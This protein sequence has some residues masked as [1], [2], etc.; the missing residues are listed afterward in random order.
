MSATREPADQQERD[1]IRNDL[2]VTM[3][4]EAAAG[5]GKTTNLVARMVNLVGRDVCSSASLAAIT[6]TV[7]AAAQL[8]ERFQEG[9]E[10][11]IRQAGSE[12]ER[13]RLREALDG[14]DRGFIGT[15]HA[16]CARLL[17][18]RPVEAGLDPEFEEVDE[19]EAKRRTEEFWN[20]W[21]EA[22]ALAGN[23][24]IEEARQ[25]ELDRSILRSGFVRI[26]EYPDITMV[27]S[28]TPRPDLRAAC[29]VLSEILDEVVPHLPTDPDR[30]PDAF[31][32]LI[33]AV[34]R[35]RDA[36]DLGEV[37]GQLQLLEE[38]NHA[39]RK[40]VQKRWPDAATAKQLGLRYSGFVTGTIRPLLQ[41][42]SEHVHG[43]AI[44]LLSRA[45]RAFEEERRHEG[46]LTYQDLL[47]CARDLLRGHPGVRRYFQRRFTHVLVDEF[48]DT[49]PLQAEI[50]FYLTGENVTERNWRALVPRPGSLFIVGDP[51]QSIYRF[52]RA[53]ITTYLDVRKRIEATGGTIVQLSTNFRSTPSICAFVNETFRPLFT[54][55]DVDAGRQAPHV[56]LTPV[57]PTPA[58]HGVF[59]LETPRATNDGMAHAEARCVAEWIRRAVDGGMRIRDE[60]EERA[61]R[62]SDVLL[63]S[64]QRPR[65]STYA[66]ALEDL[67]VP[68]E[69][70]GSKAFQESSALRSAMPLLRAIVDPDDVVSLAGFLRGPL[71]GVDDDAL[72]RFVRAGGAF[73]PFR[74]VPAETDARIARG[75]ETVRDAIREAE[76]HPPAAALGRLFDRI[77]LNALAASGERGGTTSGN[78][79]LALSIAR[80]ESA[81]GQSLAMIVDELEALLEHP[82]DLG[83]L[84]VDPARADAVRLMNLHQ[85]KGLEAPVVFLIDPAEPY[86]FPIDL[87]VDRSGDESRGYLAVTRRGMYG[88]VEIGLPTSWAAMQQSER[89]FK[90]AE[91]RRLL[92]VAAT[93][94]KD[95]LV[96]GF[97]RTVKG[98]EGAWRELAAR[99]N[100]RLFTLDEPATMAATRP[101]ATLTFPEAMDAIAG[102]FET[103]RQGSYSVLPITKIAHP[104]HAAL[105][106][107]EEGLGK[108]TSWGRV[109]H[110][111]FEAMLRVDALDVRLYAGNLLKDEERDAVELAEVM[112]VVEA[113]QSSSL[114]Q[115]VKAAEERFV[116]VPFA[117]NVSRREAGLD[118]EDGETLLHGTIDLVFREGP[119]WFIVDYKSDSTPG[120]LE[121][122]VAY[123]AAQ[124]ELYARFWSRLTGSP[125]RAGLFFVDGCIERWV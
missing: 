100:D 95:L 30:Q 32:K 19:G 58:I 43:V 103:A 59:A 28:R 1:A 14:I 125:T 44:E 57:H 73:S 56:D 22:E 21:Y 113:V 124:V 77:G 112:R 13:Q 55:A 23:P 29:E 116:E 118:D 20:R 25:L 31:E 67:G 48:Q 62:W 115:R 71:C 16:F 61:L 35:R 66:A 93:R 33:V 37:R 79:L 3:L 15:T 74:E 80:D 109:L 106:R 40:P 76:Q 84:D 46:K 12:A 78:L 38:A 64:A 6:F 8:R 90:D 11:A 51:K 39:S 26:V 111:L 114:W 85:V 91:R 5:T 98:V 101:S 69:I 92:Y 27:S 107:A 17:R 108:G 7:K 122:L 2:D 82:P 94:A 18:E 36:T 68:Y 10:D 120:R 89:A 9:L 96:V 24:R 53:D 75:L 86:E 81:K 123:Y 50:L 65:L 60:E 42:W 34:L 45:A 72:A 83:E 47:V 49:D 104:S 41:Q 70:T 102:R 97:H 63:I 52:R 54:G 4:V 121:A 117:L 88:P 87:F 119:Q 99:V 105:V 110:R